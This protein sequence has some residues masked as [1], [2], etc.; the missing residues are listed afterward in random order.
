MKKFKKSAFISSDLRLAVFDRKING[1]DFDSFIVKIRPWEH[2]HFY[3]ERRKTSTRG[4][5]GTN[6][7]TYS[8]NAQKRDFPLR[9]EP[10]QRMN[11]L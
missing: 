2:L 10:Y 5:L 6:G 8:G 7:L 3:G 1:G 9:K 11:F 4:R